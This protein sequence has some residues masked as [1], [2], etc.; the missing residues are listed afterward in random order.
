MSLAGQELL[1]GW[2]I[3]RKTLKCHVLVSEDSNKRALKGNA[4]HSDPLYALAVKH[5][6]AS[7]TSVAALLRCE[8]EAAVLEFPSRLPE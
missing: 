8:W 1:A 6:V 4:V 7:Y 3:V 2:L 5:A